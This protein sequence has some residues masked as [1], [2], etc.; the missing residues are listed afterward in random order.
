[1]LNAVLIFGFV[2]GS[3]VSFFDC[4]IENGWNSFVVFKT[5]RAEVE[6]VLKNPDDNNGKVTYETESGLVHVEYSA[7]PCSAD[8]WGRGK[9]NVPKNV[10]LWYQVVLTKDL[11]LGKL[12]WKPE[13]YERVPDPHMKDM[14]GYFNKRDGIVVFTKMRDQVET[15]VSITYER[16][17]PLSEKFKCD[18]L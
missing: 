4:G 13:L 12:S 6:N 1:M 18:K 17:K 9:F 11:E 5:T 3:I 8:S 16:S 10:V 7:E 15:V 14:F 2:I